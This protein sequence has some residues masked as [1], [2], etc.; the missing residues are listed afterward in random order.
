MKQL[1]K[2]L[3]LYIL[4]LALT[5]PSLVAQTPSGSGIPLHG[6]IL[7][8]QKQPIPNATI[9]LSP[10]EGS[11]ISD[12]LGK[13]TIIVP[14][15]GRYTIVVT[16]IGYQQL[17]NTVTV[18]KGLHSQTWTLAEDHTEL[19]AARVTA[20]G[21]AEK[22]KKQ[23]IKA[24]V[25]NTA[26]SRDQPSTL[27]EL[28]NRSA[29]IRIRQSGGLGSN[30]NLLLNGFQNR[31]IK[32][33][34][35][36]IPLDYL[37]AGFDI[38]LVPVNMLDH[39]EV[40]KGVLPTYLGADALGGAV[41]LVTRTNSKSFAALSYEM[42][43][44]HTHRVSL[45][46]E[47]RGRDNKFIAGLNG[48]FNYSDNNYGIDVSVPDSVTGV[49]R[50]YH[51][52]AFHNKFVN[53]YIEGFAG[54]A[55]RKWA[56]ELRVTVTQFSIHKQ[57]Q[58]GST[59]DKPFGAARGI[60]RS[61]VPSVIY[62][63]SLFDHKLD[64]NQFFVV[65]TL[66][67]KMIDT[68]HGRYDWLGK[69]T[70]SPT[71]M[72]ELST[73]GSL[74]NIDYTYLTSRTNI[75]YKLSGTQSLSLNGVITKYSRKGK[76][77]YGYKFSNGIDVLSI[78]ANYNKVILALGLAS[79][80]VKG[81]LQNN[82]IGKYFHYT[83]D[84]SDGDYQGNEVHTRNSHTN[85]GLADGIKYTLNEKS[86]L[87]LSGETSLR[88]PEQDELF[89]DG[90]L[91]LSNFALKPERSANINL[92]YNLSSPLAYSIEINTFYRYTKD[93]ILLMPIN[94]IYSQSQNVDKVRGMGL[95]ADGNYF[96]FPWLNL[97]ANFT[98]QDLRLTGTGYATTE[99]ARLKNTP[100]FFANAGANARIEH[101]LSRRDK[102]NM[103]WFYSFVREYYL[104]YIPKKAEPA[105]F[106]GLF[107]R[108]SIDAR[109]IIPDQSVHTAGFTYYPTPSLAIGFQLKNI[110]NARV[111]D[112]FKIQNPGRSVSFKI[113]YTL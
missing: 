56:D 92:G 46:A 42:G 60:Q 9:L 23:P 20:L 112:N 91:K 84:A 47:Y 62:K 21:G 76:D 40:Y 82:L 64:I 80:L 2:H 16:C 1:Y 26:A 102:L 73:G 105:G 57:F 85:W 107:G 27:I 11:A 71:S 36:G 34:K 43:S 66:N 93:L 29:G 83:T 89:G 52:Q 3:L 48:F 70:P 98:Y 54:I 61:F 33:F 103:Y 31:S 28:M 24:Q 113:N 19:A 7:N 106:L 108:A 32:Y 58:F 49:S 90:N 111:Y 45:N 75:S 95:N 69:F 51:V 110:F 109:N 38:S 8:A 97:N 44:F 74:S 55:N 96:L 12:S 86:F 41:N 13:F 72:G 101:L 5:M 78:P 59:M 6:S 37:G 18:K 77:P 10:H 99:G 35:D 17:T 50:N 79:D 100:Y 87:T 65:N 22:L 30:S 81:R 15:E 4:P 63:K 88:L 67:V 53:Y 94:F 25:I 39:V 68:L 104:D 14:R